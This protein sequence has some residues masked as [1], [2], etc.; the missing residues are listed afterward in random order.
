MPRVRLLDKAREEMFVYPEIE[1]TD[2]YG[3]IVIL[4]ADEPVR[5]MATAQ[6]DQSSV[7]E[8]AGQITV[9][10]LKCTTRD[11]PLGTWSRVK[12]RGRFYDVAA[13]PRF[14]PGAT[15]ASRHVSFSIRSRPGSEVG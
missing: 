9:E 14:S 15:P 6:A 13:P 3:N 1:T 12:Y 4:P 5:I 7:A 11:A 8:L 10:V 2:D